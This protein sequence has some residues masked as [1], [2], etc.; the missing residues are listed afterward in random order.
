MNYQI[1]YNYMMT[2][3]DNDTV[4]F[5]GDIT[6]KRNSSYKPYLKKLIQSLPGKKH[7]IKGNHDYYTNKFYLECG[8]LSVQRFIRT[9]DFIILHDPDDRSIET[10]DPTKLIIHGHKHNHFSTAIKK[11]KIDIGVDS[12]D[13]FPWE[14]KE[15]KK[16]TKRS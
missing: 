2:V 15:I 9:K 12:H 13:Y 14:L 4:F 7:L 16:V 3:K 8:F 5:L 1:V 6:I 10:C 11:N